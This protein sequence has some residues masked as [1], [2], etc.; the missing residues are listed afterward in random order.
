MPRVCG[1]TMYK[2]DLGASGLRWGGPALCCG[3]E[4]SC[5]GASPSCSRLCGL[6]PVPSPLWA[7]FH[8]LW[9]RVPVVWGSTVDQEGLHCVEARFSERLVLQW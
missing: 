3:E 6:G 7:L 2:F 8:P 5:P 1:E 9:L 4:A